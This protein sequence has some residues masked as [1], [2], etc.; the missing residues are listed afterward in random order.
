HGVG[1]RVL[2]FVRREPTIPPNRFEVC[3][4]YLGRLDVKLPP[5]VPFLPMA[6]TSAPVVSG[7]TERLHLLDVTTAIIQGCLE[8]AVTY[9]CNVHRAE[10][11]EAFGRS[12]VEGLRE[13]IELRPKAPATTSARI[14]P[15]GRLEA[16]PSA[17]GLA[18]DATA[19]IRALSNLA[20]G[21]FAG[22]LTPDL[23]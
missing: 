10:T 16:L 23:A 8:I 3:F 18:N 4:D 22:A 7:G 9:S 14:R 20:I 6:E 12:L 17:G 5:G 13:I 15:S 2:R 19:Q 1:Y 11:I 21:G